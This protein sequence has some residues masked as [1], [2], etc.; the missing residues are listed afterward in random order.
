VCVPWIAANVSTGNRNRERWEDHIAY[1]AALRPI[2]GRYAERNVPV[3]LLGDFNQRVPATSRNVGY[4]QYLEEALRAG[5]TIHT[6]GSVDVDGERLIDHIATTQTLRFALDRTL[7][8]KADAGR[9]VSDHPALIGR[10]ELAHL[11]SRRQQGEPGEG[12]F[13]TEQVP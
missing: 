11:D 9:R 8:R 5:Y 7:G 12:L 13:S 10:L 3:C 4:I 2:F 1:L 6:A